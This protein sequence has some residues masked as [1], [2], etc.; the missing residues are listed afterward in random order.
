MK[1]ELNIETAILT[2]HE[3][4]LF[5]LHSLGGCIS[6]EKFLINLHDHKHEWDSPV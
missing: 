2:L 4:R 6:K 1:Q 3:R 5:K